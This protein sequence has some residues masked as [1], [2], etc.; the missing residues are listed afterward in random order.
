M[1]ISKAVTQSTERVSRFNKSGEK[2][3]FLVEAKIILADD[4][5][6]S[7]YLILNYI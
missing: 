5:F 2:T 6:S 4:S 7:F 3:I 1:S